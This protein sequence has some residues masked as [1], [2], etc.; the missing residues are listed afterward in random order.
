[1]SD[2]VPQSPS[3]VTA[4]PTDYESEHRLAIVMYGGVSLAVYIGGIARELLGIVR[5]TSPRR[6]DEDT[7]GIPDHELS[8]SEK[9]YRRVA[10]MA[11]GV[12]YDATR[13][14]KLPIR[15]RVSIDIITGTSAGGI[16]GIFLAKALA[17][18]ASMDEILRLWVEEGDLAKLL[19]DKQSIDGVN[20]LEVQNPPVALLNGE[21]MYRK[22]LAAFDDMDRNAN[23]KQRYEP[24]RVDLFVTT[25]DI[26]GEVINLPV[27]NA[28]AQEKRHRQRF[29][30]T[31]DG[32]H[33]AEFSNGENPTLA[34]AAR[35]TSSFPFA[36]EPFT[37]NDAARLAGERAR[38]AQWQDRLMFKSGNYE[39]RPMGDGGYLDNKP[40]SYAIEELARRQSK[41]QVT[42]AMLYVEPD[43]VEID[44]HAAQKDQEAKPDAIDNAVAALISIPGYETIR[45]DLQKVVERND[46]VKAFQEL[47]RKVE[48]ALETWRGFPDDGRWDLEHL[49][50]AHGPGYYA[51]H[52][53]KVAAVIDTI[54]D[55]ICVAG[56]I[57]RPEISQVVRDLVRAW[58]RKT[59]ATAD[60]E[61]ELLLD[62][63]IDYRL[64]KLSF[65]LRKASRMHSPAIKET[66]QQLKDIY[67]GLYKVRGQLRDA[68]QNW[69]TQL[70]GKAGI[71]Q[72]EHL[73]PI[74]KLKN[75]A[76]DAAI[77]AM[78]RELEQ[79]GAQL[80]EILSR[81]IRTS[82]IESSD[83][84]KNA[85]AA[86]DEDLARLR[87][88]AKKFE[89]HD[90]VMFPLARNGGVDEGVEVHVIRVSPRDVR[91]P[92]GLRGNGLGHFAA[93]LE[94]DWRR[95]DILW[96]R[97]DA[98][99]TIIRQLVQDNDAADAIV[100][101]A[102]REIIKEQLG[103]ELR[104]RLAEAGAP[105]RDAE[106]ASVDERRRQQLTLNAAA[107]NCLADERVLQ[108]LFMDGRGYDEKIN[109]SRQLQSVGR[110]GVIVEKI[111]RTSALKASFPW[112]MVPKL[113]AGTFAILAQI[114]VPRSLISVA[115]EYWGRLLAL[116]FLVLTAAGIM[117]PSKPVMWL[118]VRGLAVVT[119]AA[120]VVF[121]LR[122]L[123]NGKFRSTI[124][125]SAALVAAIAGAIWM[126]ATQTHWKIAKRIVDVYKEAVTP[127]PVEWFL[128]GV[129]LG[130]VL[131]DVLLRGISWLVSL[132][133][134]ARPIA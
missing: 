47:E 106:P 108:K 4:T 1:M 39:T 81:Q 59:Y 118:G 63:D 25:T 52:E 84:L 30:F 111:L 130:I 92:H 53:V 54:A 72:D 42:R 124:A 128:L 41:F 68:L 27:R 38:T 91:R 99:E 89:G 103:T 79:D 131:I 127:T 51:Y 5:A 126:I 75:S 23:A 45:E 110:A 48:T 104:K 98:A 73:A 129:V 117:A 9:I 35:C 86:D 34:Y 15:K 101:E 19:N 2:A 82:L 3:A 46:R 76:R 77:A 36:F 22:L 133:R 61:M 134:P 32:G 29:H 109:R 102:H 50:A 69:V 60:A 12:P 71:D 13:D 85:L 90:M 37:W 107:E 28:M 17:N 116:I 105:K 70:I 119:G 88:Y 94:D 14:A 18:D 64:R 44:A 66:R 43:P 120:L 10:Q 24:G 20:G 6:D 7:A 56:S 125:W 62:A 115:A 49:I 122:R 113:L 65:L 95:N 55:L 96:G 16:N 78:V 83:R 58:T 121:L 31:H 26:R 67:D 123:I 74:A 57:A 40:F 8:P 87:T 100:D 132:I 11:E 97:L 21:R 93:F 112:P 80:R 33:H 114:A